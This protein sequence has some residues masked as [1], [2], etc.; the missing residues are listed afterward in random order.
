MFWEGYKNLKLFQFFWRYIISSKQ[1]EDC[2]KFCVLFISKLYLLKSF[3]HKSLRIRNLSFSGDNLNIKHEFESKM[4]YESIWTGIF[5]IINIIH[6]VFFGWQLDQLEHQTWIWEQ[7]VIRNQFQLGFSLSNYYS[8]S[9]VQGS[10]F[11]KKSE[12]I[13]KPKF[14]WRNFAKAKYRHLF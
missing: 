7:N 12:T 6:L 5:V 13:P 10:I 1:L 2:S 4:S 9:M 14:K 11:W 3:I 8:R